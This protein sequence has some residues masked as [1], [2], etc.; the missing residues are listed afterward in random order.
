MDCC[1]TSRRRPGNAGRV[2]DGDHSSSPSANDTAIA[3]S[4]ILRDVKRVMRLPMLLLCTV[5][6]ARQQSLKGIQKAFHEAMQ[7][8]PREKYDWFDVQC[9]LYSE[10]RDRSLAPNGRYKTMLSTEAA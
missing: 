3:A 4:F 6:Q 8:L 5:W 2:G 1:G 9:R 10:V 7:A